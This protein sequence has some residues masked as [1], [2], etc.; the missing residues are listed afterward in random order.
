MMT[1]IEIPRR[2]SRG[3]T[4][5]ELVTIIVI[6]GILAVVAVP[7]FFAKSSFDLQ[8]SYDRSLSAIRY[9]Q[10]LAIAE[11]R[12]VQVNFAANAITA[13]AVSGLSCTALIDPVRGAQVGVPA[14]TGVTLTG[15][16]F[17]FD[18][19]GRPTPGPVVVTLT[20]GTSSKTIT[21]EAETGHAHP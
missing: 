2:L 7:R 11:R 19:L 20:S 16:N 15:T 13:C 21:V 5:V 3:F 4:L 17:V 14:T 18:G 10:K 9:A 8:S 6:L 12:Q 1:P